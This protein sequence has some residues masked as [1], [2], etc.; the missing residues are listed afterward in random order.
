MIN[1]VTLLGN[2]G[3]DADSRTLND[4][5]KV[6]RFRMATQESWKDKASGEWVNKSEWHSVVVWGGLADMASKLTKGAKVFVQGKLQTSEWQDKEGNKRY[7][8][9]VVIQNFQ[10]V[11]RLLDPKRQPGEDADD[12][13]D[14]RESTPRNAAAAKNKW[15]DEI[16][17]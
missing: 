14:R 17:F 15:D 8:T 12:D 4:G 11:L 6:T 3:K 16:P 13:D 7:T 10:G 2:L 5:A 1:Q 9:E